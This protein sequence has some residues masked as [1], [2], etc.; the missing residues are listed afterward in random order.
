MS[1]QLVAVLAAIFAAQA[2]VVAMS[3]ENLARLNQGAPLAYSPDAFF[4]EAG[5]LDQLSLE[6]R[7]CS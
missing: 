6:A 2:R 3:A 7:N 4:A 1:P 5:N